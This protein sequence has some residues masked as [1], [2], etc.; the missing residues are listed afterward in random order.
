MLIPP[1]DPVIR[2]IDRSKWRLN[3]ADFDGQPKE[4]FSRTS[5]HLSFTDYHIPLYGGITGGHDNQVSFLE[6]VVS[7]RD[8]GEWV[9]DLD[10]LSA[11]NSNNVYILNKPV[12]CQHPRGLTPEESLI[13]MESWDEVLDR[14]DCICVIRASGNWIARL[15]ITCV[16]AQKSAA[17][18]TRI[19][20]CPSSVCWRCVKHQS[21]PIIYVY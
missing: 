10:V 11:V 21:F 2:E 5:L 8:S 13:S 17:L 3:H 7:V 20:V 6:S 19:T 15:A 16:L 12:S 4:C 18:E 9:A 14:P 1:K